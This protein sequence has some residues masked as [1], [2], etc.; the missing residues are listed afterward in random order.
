MSATNVA[1]LFIGWLFY[2]LSLARLASKSPTYH[3]ATFAENNLWDMIISLLN[4]I[5]I[6]ISHDQLSFELVD[7]SKPQSLIVA[8]FASTTIINHFI[9][10]FSNGSS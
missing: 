6:I 1:L 4:I 8:G 3:A 2:W 5:A 9:K 7:L 10:Q